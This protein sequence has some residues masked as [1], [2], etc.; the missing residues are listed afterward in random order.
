ME[1]TFSS[2]AHN[3]GPQHMYGPSVDEEVMSVK[4]WLVTLVILMIPIVNLIMPLVW[5]FSSD[6]NHNRKYFSRAYL[7]WGAA[8]TALVVI[9]MILIAG[10]LMSAMEILS[11]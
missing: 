5:A 7:I 10:S 8:W 3:P 2:P 1:Q 6:G 9:A 4:A 11:Q